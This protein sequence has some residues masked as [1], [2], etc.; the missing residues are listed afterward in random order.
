MNE[1]TILEI[2]NCD[3]F[4]VL[5]GCDR[6]NGREAIAKFPNGAIGHNQNN[7]ILLAKEGK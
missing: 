7:G 2:V 5:S 4:R 3:D 6:V 1:L